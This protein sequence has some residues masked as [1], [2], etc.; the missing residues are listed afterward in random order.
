V[1]YDLLTGRTGTGKFI[2]GEGTNTVRDYNPYDGDTIA[3]TKNFER[4]I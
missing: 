3:D 1:Y 2:C 4:I